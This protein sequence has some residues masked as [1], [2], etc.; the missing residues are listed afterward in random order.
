VPF[1]ETSAQLNVNVQATF[2]GTKIRHHTPQSH[3]HNIHVLLRRPRAYGAAQA[4][5]NLYPNQTPTQVLCLVANR[6]WVLIPSASTTN[7]TYV[8]IFRLSLDSASPLSA[9]G[10]TLLYLLVCGWREDEDGIV[11]LQHGLVGGHATTQIRHTREALHSEAQRYEHLTAINQGQP[12]GSVISTHVRV[13]ERDLPCRQGPVHSFPSAR[14]GWAAPRQVRPGSMPA[15]SQRTGKKATPPPA[16]APLHDIRRD[17]DDDDD[18]EEEEEEPTGLGSQDV[19][20]LSEEG[21]GCRASVEHVEAAHHV[22]GQLVVRVD[23]V[24]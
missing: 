23:R 16:A 24:R 21:L 7:E 18:D 17:D 10:K 3:I 9:C 14:S 13:R 11:E 20:D 2:A 15:R 22:E 12:V 6:A 19:S 1:A 4:V 8:M 5:R